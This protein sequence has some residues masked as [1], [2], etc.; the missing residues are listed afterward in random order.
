M[1]ACRHTI[2]VLR[3]NIQALYAAMG[4]AG[5][6]CRSCDEYI[7]FVI[8]K[9]GNPQPFTANALPHHADC[10]SAAKHRKRS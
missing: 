3:R 4:C 2:L 8:N 1:V 10:P 7:W 9:K 5:Q 6:R